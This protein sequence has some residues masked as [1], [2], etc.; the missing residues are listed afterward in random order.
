[1]G[2]FL[3][4]EKKPC[5]KCVETLINLLPDFGNITMSAYKDIV[6]VDIMYITKMNQNKIS[7]IS[8]ITL[9]RAAII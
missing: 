6:F 5:Q 2:G 9:G 4:L 8:C 1:L 7:L 3:F